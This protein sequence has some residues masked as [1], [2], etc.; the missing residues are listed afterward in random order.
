MDAGLSGA[1]AGAVRRGVSVVIPNY[2]H[3]QLLK[4]FIAQHASQTRAP[5]DIVV[6]DDGSTDDS[7]DMLDR[8]RREIPQLRVV[9]R[10]ENGG[11]T[12]A[13]TDGLRAARCDIICISSMDDLIE[14]RLL[15]IGERA[16]LDYPAA[17]MV[18]CDSGLVRGDR[19]QRYQL[20]LSPV[21]T[22]FDPDELVG[23]LRQKLFTPSSTSLI[24]RKSA[25][26][27]IGGFRPN[28]AWH[29]DWFAKYA[30]L[31][32]FGGVYV[33]ETLAYYRPDEAS[34]SSANVGGAGERDLLYRWLA[35]LEEQPDEALRR[36]FRQAALLSEYSLRAGW[37]L[38]RHP[39]Y[40]PYLTPRLVRR[41]LVRSAWNRIRAIVPLGWRSGLN[42]VLRRR[43]PSPRQGV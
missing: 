23:I 18:F 26:E 43:R 38:W 29:S 31:L 39:R 11:P 5:D 27:A 32:Q 12:E 33:P 19:T 22:Y 24:F 15:E 13:V 14:S 25:L 21:T 30:V 2:N 40:R 10:A 1:D 36:R 6:V 9:R 17:G 34:Y 4:N 35:V 8:L 20:G 42:I 41:L 7:L 37:W 3:G 28:L 16:L